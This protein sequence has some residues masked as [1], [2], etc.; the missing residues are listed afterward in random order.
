[1]SIIIAILALNIIII[2]H[3]LGHFIAAKKMGIKVLEFSLFIGPKIISIQRGDTTYTLR[4]IPLIAYVKME[5]EEDDSDSPAA[6]R[7]KSLTARM[8]TIVSGPLANLMLA[9]IILTA[10][11]SISGFATTEIGYVAENSPAEAAG[12]RKG[13]KIV[14]Y[15]GKRTYLPIDVIQFIYISKGAPAEI[16]YERE[17]KRFS[18]TI[19]PVLHPASVSP[20]IGVTLGGKGE[21]DSNVISGLAPDLPAEEMGLKAGDRIVALN[22][23]EVNTAEEII[24]FLNQNGFKPIEVKVLRDGAEINVTLT[25]VEA[26]SEEWYDAGILF[27][28]VKGG[29][30]KS[31]AQAATYTFT[32]IR[33]TGYSLVWLIT[34]KASVSELIGPIGMVS[35]ISAAVRQAPSIYDMLL[36][37]LNTTALFSIALGATNLIPFPVLDGGRIVMLLVE[38]VRGKPLSQEKEAF[39]SMVGFT[40][41]IL[42]GLFVAYNDIIRLVTG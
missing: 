31:L 23:T 6:F 29:F 42:L 26:K 5:G 9:V 19:E 35:T 27:M 24:A 18:G 21:A 34:G 32:I 4:L 8:I 25:P 12:I 11:F 10:V 36:E 15:D 30:F 3:E 1:M 28:P 37:L 22:G 40:L 33:S 41:I 38:A 7:N 20:K 13:D 17:G 14:S 2:V 39:I 16:E